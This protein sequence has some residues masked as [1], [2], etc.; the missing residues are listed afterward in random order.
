V[1]VSNA[2]HKLYFTYNGGPVFRF[3][4]PAVVQAD[5]NEPPAVSGDAA[6]NEEPKDADGYARR[7]AAFAARRDFDHAIADTSK[8]CELAPTEPK[9][10]FQRANIH[11]QNKQPALAMADLDQTLKLDSKNVPALLLRARLRAGEHDKA[12]SAADLDAVAGLVSKESDLRL[13][14]AAAYMSSDQFDA[15]ISQYDQWISNHSGDGRLVQAY[16]GRCWARAAVGRDLNKALDDCN[17]AV[18]LSPKAAAI[19]DSR[20]LVELRLG[21]NDK[22]IADYDAALALQPKLGWSLYGRGLAKMRKGQKTDGAA[23]LTAATAINPK[24]PDLMKT[25][26]IVGPDG[27]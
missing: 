13:T 23:D 17:R 5:A 20:G 18:N 12:G 3:D 10:F 26:G 27:A 21:D 22:A 25:Y 11:A 7:G 15:A 16:N 19:L 2:Q 24:L 9:Y 1:Y 6:G 4:A 14:I 8:A